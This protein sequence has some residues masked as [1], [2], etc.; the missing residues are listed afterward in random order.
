M[1]KVHLAHVDRPNDMIT[2]LELPELPRR[3]DIIVME[4]YNK[5]NRYRV[6]NIE[7]RT[8]RT[9][10]LTKIVAMVVLEDDA[11][12]ITTDGPTVIHHRNIY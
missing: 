3:A 8:T 11:T 12:W 4:N 2:H 6:E 7:W 9:G 5:F 10:T 1:I